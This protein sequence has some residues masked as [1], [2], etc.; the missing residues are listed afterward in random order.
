MNRKQLNLLIVTLT[1]AVLMGVGCNAKAPGS[2]DEKKDR[3]TTNNTS[4]TDVLDNTQTSTI[5]NNITQTKP[6]KKDDLNKEENED[7]DN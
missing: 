6:F 3:Q 7:D 1:A 2:F 4:T 5:T